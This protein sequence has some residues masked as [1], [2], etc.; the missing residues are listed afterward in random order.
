MEEKKCSKCG[1]VKLVSEFY[2]RNDRMTGYSSSCKKCKNNKVDQY[3]K[4]KDGLVTTIY[5]GQRNSSRLRNSNH[6]DYSKEQ[7][8][9]WLFSQPNFSELYDNWVASGYNKWLKPSCDRLKDNLP[10]SIANL[11][12]IT[13]EE[14]NLKSHIGMMNGEL[15]DNHRPVVQLNMNGDFIQ[16]F[17]SIS[18]A[19]RNIPNGS[20]SNIIAAANGT[21]KHSRGFKWKFKEDY[22]ANNS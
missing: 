18:E 3:L 16:E 2:K 11:Q 5:K 12:L 14:N 19:A 1:D 21:T 15:K 22:H 9:E 8:K 10:Y 13:W 6:P 17:H 7:L 20:V 4:T